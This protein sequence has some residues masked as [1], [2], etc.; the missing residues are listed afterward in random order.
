MFSR[1]CRAGIV[2]LQDRHGEGSQKKKHKAKNHKDSNPTQRVRQENRRRRRITRTINQAQPTHA[3]AHSKDR[4]ASPHNLRVFDK[5][6][7]KKGQTDQSPRHRTKRSQKGK[8]IGPQDPQTPLKDRKTSTQR[9]DPHQR[10][11]KTPWYPP[12]SVP[13]PV[14]E[15]PKMPTPALQESRPTW[16]HYI[17]NL[18]RQVKQHS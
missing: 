9:Q 13:T 2:Y 12:R 7:K 10:K 15:P 17:H 3:T 14:L 6:H 4:N 11:N 1:K 8:K 16:K 18:I 5:T